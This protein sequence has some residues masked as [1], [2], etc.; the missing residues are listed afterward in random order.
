MLAND[1]Y[2]LAHSRSPHNP[3]VPLIANAKRLLPDTA[4]NSTTN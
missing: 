4:N 3:D 1:L 2:H